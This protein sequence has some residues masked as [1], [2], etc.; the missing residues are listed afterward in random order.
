MTAPLRLRTAPNLRDF[1]GHL[2]VDGRRVRRG[3]LF[4]SSQLSGLD[5]ADQAVVLGL[6]IAC[7]IDLRAGD[8]RNAQPHRCW[9]GHAADRVESAKTSLASEMAGQ[10]ASTSGL[11]R[12][13]AG[14]TTL[15]AGMAEIYVKEYRALFE[16][17]AAGRVPLLVNCTAGKDRT[18]VACALIL[19]VLGVPR[20]AVI[21]DYV[22]TNARFKGLRST[23]GSQPMAGAAGATLATLADSKAARDAI[24]AADPA[25]LALALDAVERD[26]G[27]IETYVADRLGIGA[28]GIAAMRSILT[29]LA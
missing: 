17:L 21:A 24:W 6:N 27:S 3:V 20:Q 18:G 12:V 1:G 26:H 8:E 22:E 28:N 13:R 19:S 23:D 29:E 5:E 15:Y 9:D 7:V 25:F 11:E 16:R 2:T 14:F 10:L 4:R